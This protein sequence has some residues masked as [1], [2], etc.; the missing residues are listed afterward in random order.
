M[1]KEVFLKEQF[2][3][4]HVLGK[5]LDFDSYTLLANE[6]IDVYKPMPAFQD[7]NDE[8]NIL[9]KFRKSVFNPKDCDAAYNGLKYGATLTDNRGIAAGIVRASEYQTLPS[10]QGQRRW[11][12]KKE[13]A[14]LEYFADGSP[15]SLF[16][17]DQAE[18]LYKTVPSEP[19]DGRGGGKVGNIIIKGGSIWIV[20][21]AKE[22]DFDKWF[23]DTKKL[24]PE[25][26]KVETEKLV[27]KYISDTTYGEGVHSGVGGYFD[28]YPRIP[29]CRE[30]SWSAGNRSKWE[31]AFPL[32]KKAS[33]IYKECLPVRWQGQYDMTK[34]L[35]PDFL[36]EDTVYTTVTINKH[37]RTACHR[38]AGDLCDDE[39]TATPRGFSN[40]TV[41]T[42]GKN[43]DGFYLCFP[44]YKV[45]ANIQNGDFI[46]MDAHKIHGNVPVISCDEGFQRVS[47]VMYFREKMI[48]C[49]S[50]K[51]E[52]ARKNYV[53]ARKKDTSHP[54]WHAGWNGIS[55][56]MFESEDWKKYLA[57]NGLLDDSVRL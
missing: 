43:F 30:T 2:D 16:E 1:V 25:D 54:D 37:F 50:K 22:I 39:N 44:E 52:E 28:R 6:D 45:A 27:A 35:D 5:Y 9:L 47:V 18:T 41:V 32:F 48:E 33:Q 10:G 3:G 20:K 19:L 24:G 36:I 46:M 8:R 34:K 49:E 23:H 57:L 40:L 51:I 13:K 15:S 31:A 29:F 55:P 21:Y 53:Y 4:E 26:R 38:D 17:E 12:T 14:V 56:G 42:N 7:K 11:V